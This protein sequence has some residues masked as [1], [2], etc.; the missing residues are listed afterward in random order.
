M[1]VVF[2]VTRLS[3]PTGGD[4]KRIPAGGGHDL[5]ERLDSE[6]EKA[7]ALNQLLLSEADSKLH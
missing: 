3:T 7:F 4:G 5:Q 6:V 2:V 1:T